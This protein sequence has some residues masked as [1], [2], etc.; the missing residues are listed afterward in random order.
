MFCTGKWWGWVLAVHTGKTTGAA[1]YTRSGKWQPVLP[2]L[3]IGLTIAS[4]YSTE[5]DLIA[6]QVTQNRLVLFHRSQIAEE[7]AS[8]G[9]CRG[10]GNIFRTLAAMHRSL[11]YGDPQR[12]NQKLGKT[13]QKFSL[14]FSCNQATERVCFGKGDGVGVDSMYFSRL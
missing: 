13:H 12:T 11:K 14:F 10:L 6:L 7:R 8:A 2:E 5:T 3:N 1:Q 9:R 4:H